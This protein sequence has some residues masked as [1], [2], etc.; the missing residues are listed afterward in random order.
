MK[1][2]DKNFKYQYNKELVLT[3]VLHIKL[4][5]LPPPRFLTKKRVLSSVKHVV[6]QISLIN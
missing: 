4:L 5:A 3:E 1:V 2:P 6:N